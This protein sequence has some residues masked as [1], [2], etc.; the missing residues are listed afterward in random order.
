MKRMLLVFALALLSCSTFNQLGAK[1]S[2]TPQPEETDSPTAK[3][4]PAKKTLRPTPTEEEI[5]QEPLSIPAYCTILGESDTRTVLFGHDIYLFWGWLAS[6]EE[7]VVDFIKNAVF[8][9]TFDGTE[10]VG[11]EPSEVYAKDDGYGVDWVKP[12]GVLERG[13]YKT[14][15]LVKFENKIFD[16]WDYYGPGSD[17]ETIEDTCYLTIE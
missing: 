10:I 5:V 4:V 17:Y 7:Q 13:E 2:A 3:S 14:T 16:G 1:P 8:T 6:T 11:V 12:L 15:Y 9:V